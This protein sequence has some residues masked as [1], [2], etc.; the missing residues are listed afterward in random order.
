MKKRN[1]HY[2]YK[3]SNGLSVKA[4][5]NI[6]SLLHRAIS[7]SI[8]LLLLYHYGISISNAFVFGAISTIAYF[9]VGFLG[10]VSGFWP[11]WKMFE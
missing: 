7:L 11:K 3:M 9:I 8:F 1:K 2:K 10:K 6:G 4:N 5:K